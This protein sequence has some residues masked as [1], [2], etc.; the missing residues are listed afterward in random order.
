MAKETPRTVKKTTLGLISKK[1]NFARAATFFCTF[2]SRCFAR[3][4]RETSGNFLAKS[5][6]EEMSYL[7]LVHY[8]FFR[9]RSYSPWWPLAF[10]SFSPPLQNFYVVLPTKNAP[11][12][13]YLSLWLSAGLFLV[14]LHWPVTYILFF[15][16]FFFFRLYSKFVDMKQL[17]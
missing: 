5:F 1:S 7:F 3:V 13:F 2:L 4:Q 17:I 12:L 14:E 10:L 16:V 6:M 8:F 9:C 15:S 11:F